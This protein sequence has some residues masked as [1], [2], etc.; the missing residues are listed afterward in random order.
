MT[1]RQ[2]IAKQRLKEKYATM[3]QQENGMYSAEIRDEY[4]DIESA[5][6][7]QRAVEVHQWAYEH[8]CKDLILL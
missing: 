4:G 6:T 7:C 8:G 5:I 1:T 3:S 2:A